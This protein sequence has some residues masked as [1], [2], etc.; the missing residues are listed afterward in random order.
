M[1]KHR[2]K[3]TSRKVRATPAPAQPVLPV[4]LLVEWIDAATEDGWYPTPVNHRAHRVTTAGF[5]L[6]E[7][8]DEVVLAGDVSTDTMEAGKYDTNRRI[9]I[10]KAWIKSRKKLVL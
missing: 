8:D 3:A 2:Q 9:A 5:L 6:A 1:P 10:P 7:T 4:L